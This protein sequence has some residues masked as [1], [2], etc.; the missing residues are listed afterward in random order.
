VTLEQAL[1]QDGEAA[2]GMRVMTFLRA[3]PGVGGATARRLM[4]EGG[5]D[6]GRRAA[7]LTVGQSARLLAAVAAMD[8]ELAARRGR[9]TEHPGPV[10]R[11]SVPG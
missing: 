7:A 8:A 10:L 3:I 6:P 2:R 11:P 1:A 5:I 9:R 4:R